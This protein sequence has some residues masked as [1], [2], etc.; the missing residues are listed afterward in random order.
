MKAKVL[1]EDINKA[2][3][4]CSRFSSTRV[5]LP[6]LAN[7]LIET[8]KNKLR[9]AS[10]NLEVSV[11]QKIAAKIDEEGSISIPAR[12]INELISNLKPGQMDLIAQ[13]ETLEI[14]TPDFESTL[15]GMNTSDFPSVPQ[16][17]GADSIIFPYESFQS[18]LSKILYSV[19]T[20]ET[21]P[22]LTG[23]LFIIKSD[24]TILVSTDGFRLSQ[25][26]L[27]LKGFSEEK[28][29]IIPKATLSELVRVTG[30]DEIEFSFKKTENQV[31]LGLE[32]VVMSSRVIEGDFPDFEKI[33]PKKTSLKMDADKEEL[34]RN[35]K[36]AS[37]F[38]KDSANVVKLEFDK[39][40]LEVKA[41]SQQYGNQKGRVDIK[42]DGYLDK[43]FTIA[44]NYRFLEE[45]LS[46]CQGE[47]VQ[48]EFSDSNDPALFLDPKDS[49]YL[50][51]IMPVK[52]QE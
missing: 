41:E 46:C 43:K 23:V 5:Q 22:I 14:K 19:S 4:I 3:N 24:E 38:A 15:S 50:H 28:R 32:N 11:S 30:G 2:L 48:M 35:I 21:R 49:N 40:Y 37:V 25:K 7:I 27:K 26:K 42:L 1:Q 29:V 45:F 20:D 17:V 39:D 47:D 36:L 44:F 9:I 6:V 8:Q 51:I 13:K 12:L 34:L 33:I 16:S 18:A 31:I 52:I 10:T